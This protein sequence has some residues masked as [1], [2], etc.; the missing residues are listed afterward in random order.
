MELTREKVEWRRA[1]D[2][3]K[4]TYMTEWLDQKEL[5]TLR[6]GGKK[7]QTIILVKAKDTVTRG[8]SEATT[9]S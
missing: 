6:V 9:Q 1:L 4:E 7:R 8:R 2:K 5:K 3:S